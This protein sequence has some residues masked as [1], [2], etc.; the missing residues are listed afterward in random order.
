MAVVFESPMRSGRLCNEVMRN[1][2]NNNNKITKN[3]CDK[4]I[5]FV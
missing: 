4:E 2:R 5:L 3:Q 1:K